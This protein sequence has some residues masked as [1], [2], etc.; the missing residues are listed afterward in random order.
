[1]FQHQANSA[2]WKK[3]EEYKTTQVATAGDVSQV[4]KDLGEKG[5]GQQDPAQHALVIIQQTYLLIISCI[6]SEKNKQFSKH[7][8]N[9]TYMY[10]QRL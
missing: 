1:M 8:V 4:I 9:G 6:E 2:D 5:Q 10:H 7:L 3:E